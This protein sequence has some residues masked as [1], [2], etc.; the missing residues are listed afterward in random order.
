MPVMPPPYTPPAS[1]P[2]APATPLHSVAAAD[3]APHAAAPLGVFACGKLSEML[4][5]ARSPSRSPAG[6]ACTL[7]G[8]HAPLAA[9]TP[10]PPG[11][12][13]AADDDDGAPVAGKVPNMV[14]RPEAPRSA[15]VACSAALTTCGRSCSCARLA[16]CHQHVRS[17]AAS[18]A[19]SPLPHRS[20]HACS[21]CTITRKPRPRSSCRRGQRRSCTGGEAGWC[22]ADATRLPNGTAATQGTLPVELRVSPLPAAAPGS[23]S[24]SADML[25]PGDAP[26]TNGSAG[27][28]EA[29]ED[30]CPPPNV[31]AATGE[32]MPPSS[33]GACGTPNTGPI[34]GGA[35][36]PPNTGAGGAAPRAGLLLGDGAVAAT[37]ANPPHGGPAGSSPAATFVDADVI[38]IP[39]ASHA[40]SNMEQSRL[41]RSANAAVPPR[42]SA[43][44]PP[45]QPP[46]LLRTS[47]LPLRTPPSSA[48]AARTHAGDCFCSSA[49]TSAVS[50]AASAASGP[51]C[52]ARQR[53]EA[54]TSAAPRGWR[55]SSSSA[56]RAASRS[57]CSWRSGS[58][59]ASPPPPPTSVPSRCVRCA[60]LE[61]D[62]SALNANATPAPPPPLPLAPPLPAPAPAER[63]AVPYPPACFPQH[64]QNTRSSSRTPPPYDNASAPPGTSSSA[65]ESSRKPCGGTRTRGHVRHACRQVVALTGAHLACRQAGRL[66]PPPAHIH[67]PSIN[68]ADTPERWPWHVLQL[69]AAAP[70]ASPSTGR[71]QTWRSQWQA[72]RAAAQCQTAAGSRPCTAF[73]AS[74]PRA[75]SGAA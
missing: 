5:H 42:S 43:Q 55:S 31:K 23:R 74:T 3:P 47:P 64:R 57:E 18:T 54:S 35:G 15:R 63:S 44:P 61:D 52:G 65:H 30:A 27:G 66:C 40:Q 39:S 16:R 56:S 24:A 12:G 2:P 10:A 49:S 8:N 48:T 28:P 19:T 72:H 73:S 20:R 59:A 6:V 38:G 4:S 32:C 7:G 9:A 14:G 36:A 58:R 13:P 60:A 62:G 53:A 26:N 37:S 70:A 33:D 75:R 67:P 68:H 51:A 34:R 17:S 41:S 69:P 21:T 46:M 22:T 50:S 25:A 11:I 71:A 29:G 45:P 1:G